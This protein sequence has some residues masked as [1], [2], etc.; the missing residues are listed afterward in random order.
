MRRGIGVR[1]DVLP[2][3]AM[4]LPQPIQHTYVDVPQTGGQIIRYVVESGLKMLPGGGITFL[5]HGPLTEA[6]Q[7]T[8]RFT[9]FGTFILASPAGDPPFGA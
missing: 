9:I 4:S 8:A 5:G 3:V 2:S 7:W 1:V 6:Q